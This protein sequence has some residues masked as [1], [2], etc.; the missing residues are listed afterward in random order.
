[1]LSDEHHAERHVIIRSRSLSLP[2]VWK[3]FVFCS[4]SGC[5]P[6][7]V[8]I[9]FW[10]C[11]QGERPRLFVFVHDRDTLHCLLTLLQWALDV[12]TVPTFDTCFTEKLGPKDA[13]MLVHD[14]R[15]CIAHLDIHRPGGNETDGRKRDLGVPSW[16]Q[17]PDGFFS[18]F[19][20]W[21]C[22]GERPVL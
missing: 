4:K 6:H 21:G 7:C 8:D 11:A 13:L 18:L 22:T 5:W 3:T 19:Y 17:P 2:N 9:T 20:E 12:Q 15:Y 10:P 1:V 16:P 14:I